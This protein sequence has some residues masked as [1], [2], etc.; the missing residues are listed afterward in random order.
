M[1]RSPPAASFARARAIIIIASITP[2]DKASLDAG[3]RC[4]VDVESLISSVIATSVNFGSFP[5]HQRL[6]IHFHGISVEGGKV[7][8][9]KEQST[10]Q[11]ER[12]ELGCASAGSAIPFLP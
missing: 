3:I 4:A 8:I 12:A 11:R 1:L 2:P 6:E 7:K 5:R 10:H 9:K